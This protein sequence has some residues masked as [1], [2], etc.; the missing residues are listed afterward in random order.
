MSVDLSRY[1]PNL[2]P[3]IARFQGD[4]GALMDALE[5]GTITA[6]GFMDSMEAGIARYHLAALME[7]QQT[8]QIGPLV[9]PWVI[10]VIA[11][12]LGWLRK[13]AG[14]IGR[15]LDKK[16]DMLKRWR[17]RALSYGVAIQVAYWQGDIIRQVGRPLPLP[18]MPA[19]GTQCMNNCGCHWKIVTVSAKLGHYNG[20]WV[21][22]KDDS[23]QTCLEREKH[24]APVKIRNMQLLPVRS[25]EA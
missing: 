17:A 16:E 3:L 9:E 5:N 7:G 18:A 12:Q 25:V 2:R 23:C 6:L 19:Q 24:W 21:R 11:Y 22:A 10:G 13:F 14:D 1:P 15:N 8:P 4:I 20:Y